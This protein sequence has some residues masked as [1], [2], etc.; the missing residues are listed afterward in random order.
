MNQ[1]LRLL[2][3]EATDVP[4]RMNTGF[5]HYD[6][7]LDGSRA[8]LLKITTELENYNSN[9]VD[10]IYRLLS[11]HIITYS[12]IMTWI[13]NI[14]AAIIFSLSAAETNIGFII[15]SMLALMLVIWEAYHNYQT[16]VNMSILQTGR[17]KLIRRSLL[18]VRKRHVSKDKLMMA[19]RKI[20]FRL[21]Y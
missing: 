9:S 13:R 6:I 21:D 1:I 12:C 2:I 17:V 16:Q 11:P 15:Y 14:I 3:E 18:A 20:R 5:H 8:T 7:L 19:V 4:T 10:V